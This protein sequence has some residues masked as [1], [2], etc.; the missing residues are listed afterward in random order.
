MSSLPQKCNWCANKA[1]FCNIRR[2]ACPRRSRF[3]LRVRCCS[4]VPE[5][6][7]RWVYRKLARYM[8]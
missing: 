5:F 7:C 8:R 1:M 3:L 2:A 6:L 4:H